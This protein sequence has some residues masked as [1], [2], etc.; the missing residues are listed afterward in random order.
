MNKIGK[1]I[2]VIMITLGMSVTAIAQ[3]P[4]PGA[5]SQAER[6]KKFEVTGGALAQDSVVQ[7]DTVILFDPVSYEETFTVTVNKLSIYDYCQQV[8]GISDPDMLLDGKVHTIT[9][10][11][12]YDKMQIQWNQTAGKI[13]TIRND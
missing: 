3:M 5:K 10:P 8:L 11:L 2:L 13:D 4:G 1:N 12:T 9:N 7:I 6:Y